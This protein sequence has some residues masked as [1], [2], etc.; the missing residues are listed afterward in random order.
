MTDKPRIHTNKKRECTRSDRRN[1][2]GLSVVP[3]PRDYEEQATDLR[4][5]GE[6]GGGNVKAQSASAMKWLN[7]IAQG[8]SPGLVANMNRP[9][10]G[11]RIDSGF[12]LSPSRALRGFVLAESMTCS[13][14]ARYL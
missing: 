9:E 11:D 7:R 8:F 5:M 12:V 4:K 14:G 6:G 13:V 1:A 2:D 3:R 10:S